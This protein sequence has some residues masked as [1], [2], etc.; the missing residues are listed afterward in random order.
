ML[1]N[2]FVLYTQTATVAG[3]LLTIWLVKA[4]VVMGT[5]LVL[6]LPLRASVLSAMAL[7]QVGEFS[8]VLLNAASSHT[9]LPDRLEESLIAAVIL[10]ML[11]TPLA[12]AAGPRL[13]AGMGRFRPLTRLLEVKPAL[14]A[15]ADSRKLRGHIVI[16]GYGVAGRE[17][18]RVLSLHGV[19]HLVIDL[20]PDN[21]RQAEADGALAFFGDITNAEVLSHL[22]LAD[23]DQVVL[24]IN[25]PGAAVR[26]VK[27]VRRVAPN[28]HL[29]VRCR[30]LGDVPQ[31]QRAGASLVVP[32]ER[33][34]A[35]ALTALVMEHKGLAN[36]LVDQEVL[37]MR[38]RMDHHSIIE[39]AEG[40]I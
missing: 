7:A 21:V 37:E 28:A 10:S 35:V 12:L 27:S 4:A 22:Y 39:D 14:D 1:L 25:D 11:I 18:V 20:N 30:Y 23:A 36:D 6:R 19:E 17:L 34:A 5:S 13:A 38:R 2:P 32:A 40:G 15:D 16:G 24:A 9:L 26:A 3:L 33:E 29:V 8:F 31:L